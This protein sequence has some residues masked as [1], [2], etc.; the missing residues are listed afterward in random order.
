[1]KNEPGAGSDKVLVVIPAR[2]GSTRFPGKALADLAGAPLVVRVA[3]AAGAVG[4]ADEI[5]VATDDERILAAVR[6]AG[7]RCEMTGDHATGTDRIGEVASRHSAGII[8]NL[9]GDEPLLAAEDVERLIA[10]LQNDPSL[11]IVTCGHR[12]E[13]AESWRDPNQVKVVR[14]TDGLA[15]YFSRAPIPGTFPG[16]EVSAWDQALRHVGIY[17]F[18]RDSLQ[19][20]LAL[21]RTPLE[22]TEGLEQLRALEN[23]MRIMVLEIAA[24]PVGVDTPADLD[25]VR[26]LWR[27]RS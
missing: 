2:Y 4:S 7:H 3:E 22:M 13:T 11:D 15:L 1:M 18:R 8:V 27:K 19:R 5:V 17:A 21:G 14:D 20:F 12:F 23:G 26:E 24:A 25:Q 9:Q 16:A 10:A 6:D